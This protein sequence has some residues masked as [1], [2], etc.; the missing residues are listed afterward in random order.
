V[1][2]HHQQLHQ[3]PHQDDLQVTAAAAAV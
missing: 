2:W 1:R 3:D